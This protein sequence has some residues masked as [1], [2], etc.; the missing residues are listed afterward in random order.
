MQSIT[1]KQ[2]IVI[3]IVFFIGMA[4]YTPNSL[5]LDGSLQPLAICLAAF[6]PACCLQIS[7]LKFEF[8]I[9][10]IAIVS[11]LQGFLWYFIANPIY[12]SNA[13]LLGVQVS[14]G[15]YVLLRLK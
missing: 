15:S 2:L 8:T 14:V 10:I 12:P 11:A 13:I 3:L 4:I 6:L 5:S 7:K 9:P 1:T